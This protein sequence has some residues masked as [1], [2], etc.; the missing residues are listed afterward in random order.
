MRRYDIIACCEEARKEGKAEGRIK[1]R[2]EER[3][4]ILAQI[5]SFRIR[6]LPS[7]YTEQIRG[8]VDKNPD[9]RNSRKWR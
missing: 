9:S 8:I 7:D 2:G 5:L 4:T 1:G 6:D 3:A